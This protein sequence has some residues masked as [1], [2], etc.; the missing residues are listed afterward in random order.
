MSENE[1][2][3]RHFDGTVADRRTVDRWIIVGL[4]GFT[5]ILMS[6]AFFFGAALLKEL[7]A[8]EKVDRN[9]ARAT[10]FRLCTRNSVDRA[11]A[12][13]RVGRSEGM[14]ELRK[15]EAPDGLPILNC[16]PNL[17]GRGAAPLSPLQQRDFVR[18]WEQHKLM[19]AE[20]GI[21]PDSRLGEQ[22]KVNEC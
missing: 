11:F 12:H 17:L 6:V 1:D 20:L 15:L 21:C 4:F 9:S 5:L 10:A 8:I 16:A 3:D 7:A 13:S 18:R 22:T 2:D 14:R 19:P